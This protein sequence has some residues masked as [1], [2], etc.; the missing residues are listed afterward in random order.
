MRLVLSVWSSVLG[1]L[2]YGRWRGWK[3]SVHQPLCG[4]TSNLKV[5]WMPTWV[6]SF[7]ESLRFS[8]TPLVS[9]PAAVKAQRTQ[10]GWSTHEQEWSS[11]QLLL[12]RNI[13]ITGFLCR[14]SWF[15]FCTFFEEFSSAL[16][17]STS[18]WALFVSDISRVNFIS[19]WWD[20]MS[21]RTWVRWLHLGELLGLVFH[22]WTI[23]LEPGM[24]V[25]VMVIFPGAEWLEQLFPLGNL[26][27]FC[28]AGH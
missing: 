11:G 4:F 13:Q 21:S 24:M 18:I 12:W 23:F 5:E 9:L 8:S 25:V 17:N 26:W 3:Y 14:R 6:F 27:I 1:W 16:F 28:F 7:S 19:I 10:L 22:H 20:F 15:F 2:D